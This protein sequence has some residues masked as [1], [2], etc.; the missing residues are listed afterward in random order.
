MD[1]AGADLDEIG[2]VF[3][4]SSAA[5]AGGLFLGDVHPT[6]G[7]AACRAH[8]RVSPRPKGTG[9]S[10][11][12][13]T[14]G[15]FAWCSDPRGLDARWWLRRQVRA[16]CLVKARHGLLG[17][18]CNSRCGFRTGSS[19]CSIQAAQAFAFFHPGGS[20]PGSLRA[21]LVHC[22]SRHPAP[23]LLRARLVRSRS[24]HPAPRSPPA[25]STVA[26]SASPLTPSGRG[27][28]PGR[29]SV[30]RT[31]GSRH[32]AP[33]I[34]PREASGQPGR[35][36]RRRRKRRLLQRPPSACPYRS[37]RLPSCIRVAA[38]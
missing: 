31:F 35:P 3:S 17:A 30:R 5:L 20:G 14:G 10:H 24:R 12:R 28:G 25:A 19:P 8:G 22:R 2:A 34:R 16:F 33:G 13:A 7:A 32:P 21:P 1:R 4:L 38:R 36:N 27:S 15:E 9:G 29:L 23:R 11:S 37:A 6:A 18:C 26:A